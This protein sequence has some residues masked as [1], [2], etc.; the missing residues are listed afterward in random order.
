[1]DR[2]ASPLPGHNDA[3]MR[4]LREV[5]LELVRRQAEFWDVALDDD[6]V[7]TEEDSNSAASARPEGINF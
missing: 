6:N 4:A 1:M 7:D 2:R 3:G 5:P